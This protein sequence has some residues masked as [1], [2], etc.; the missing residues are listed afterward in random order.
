MGYWESYNQAANALQGNYDQRARVQA[1]SAL[2]GGDYDGAQNALN[3]AGMIDEGQKIAAQRA[4]EQY[5]TAQVDNQKADN[6]RAAAKQKLEW[7]G[8]ATQ[9]LRTVPQEQ[10]QAVLHNLL[11]P[12][13]Q[14][15]G[16]PPEAL[17]ELSQAQLTDQELDA[18]T[19]SVGG[20]LQKYQIMSTQNGGVVAV[21]PH[22]LESKQIVQGQRS[23]PAGY[24]YGQDGKL[25]AIPGGPADPSVIGAQA[26]VRR[27]AV[28]SRPMPSRGRAG[29][30]GGGGR[31]VPA[32]PPGF[33]LEK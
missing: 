10:R 6:E 30:S 2:A 12:T 31:S 22:T 21:N 24:D 27:S 3:K 33:V 29:G 8:R 7:L 17:A 4:N 18:F 1:G 14:T 15:M 26:G 16:F 5:R 28:V 32:L 20:E 11:M 9:G 25:R 23:A 13:L 19:Q